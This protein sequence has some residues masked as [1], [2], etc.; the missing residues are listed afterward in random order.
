MARVDY[1]NQPDAPEPNSIVVA[2]T[3]FVLDDRGHVL[4]IQRSDNGLWAVPGG[5]LEFGESVSECAVRE[6]L[7]ETGIN[8]EIVGLVGI[9]SDPR[10]VVAFS[11]GEVR[12]QFSICLRAKA[13]GGQTRTSV[14]SSKVQWVDRDDLHNF[15]IHPTMEL[16][17]EHGYSDQP[18]PYLG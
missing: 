5:A 2:T 15:D 8:V 17:I 12:Q 7:E 10:H 16:R 18:V 1:Y 6:T 9:Y 14:E 13:V 3:V 4:L 11:D